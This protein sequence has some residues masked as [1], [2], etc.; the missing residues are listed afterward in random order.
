MNSMWQPALHNSSKTDCEQCNQ[1]HQYDVA[2]CR[3]AEVL[4]NHAVT[5]KLCPRCMMDN[6]TVQH[7]CWHCQQMTGHALLASKSSCGMSQTHARA[8]AETN[9]TTNIRPCLGESASIQ[10]AHS[11]ACVVYSTYESTCRLKASLKRPMLCQR[12]PAAQSCIRQ[13]ALS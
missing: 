13:H 10:V 4:A 9:S 5:H 8:A 7:A 2:C 12:T 3:H 6:P 11:A 1:R